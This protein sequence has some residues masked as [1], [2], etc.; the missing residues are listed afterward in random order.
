MVG[1]G[2]GSVPPPDE[3]GVGAGSVPGVPPPE[4]PLHQQ[5]SGSGTQ[6]NP[7]PQSDA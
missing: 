4:L 3:D 7:V 1:A 6:L 5:L 2:A